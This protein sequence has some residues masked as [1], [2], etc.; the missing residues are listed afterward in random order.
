MLNFTLTQLR[1]L[2]AVDKYRHFA[3]AAKHCAISQPTL[4]MQLQKLEDCLGAPLF[5]RS[6]QPVVPTPI[7][8]SVI[9]QARTVLREADRIVE[10]IESEKDGLRGEYRLGIIPTLT[11]GV[12]PLFVPHFSRAF[13][14]V[15]LIIEEMKTELILAAL[16]DDA[17]DG[18]IAATPLED[19]QIQE[20][21]LFYERFFAYL[22]KGHPL[23]EKKAIQESDLEKYSVWLLGEGHCFR[24]QV[25]QLCGQKRPQDHVV[26]ESGAF[27]TLLS[28][29]DQG[30]GMTLIPELLVHRI[31][32]KK[33]L[34]ELSTRHAFRE[35]S[36]IRHRH[37]VRAAIT[38]ALQESIRKSLPKGIQTELKNG[39]V[40]SPLET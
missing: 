30:M 14:Q 23:L 28:L 12:L 17:L 26:F 35:V 34:R 1:Y 29:V 22:S 37:M 10:V 38:N 21:P 2:V 31:S 6:K 32:N 33:Q 39:L 40:L 20:V 36:L 7:G 13:P 19:P 25:T 8:V 11:N 16:K 9:D 24:N 18:A 3:K 4:S 15:T 27:E 5:D